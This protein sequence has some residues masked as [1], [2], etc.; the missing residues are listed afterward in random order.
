ML[1]STAELPWL[2]PERAVLQPL[3]ID[4]QARCLGGS[5]ATP[6]VEWRADLPRR[7]T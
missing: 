5:Q 7:R 4:Q 3:R 1:C 2:S 6:S